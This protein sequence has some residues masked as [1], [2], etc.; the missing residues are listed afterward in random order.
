MVCTSEAAESSQSGRSRPSSSARAIAQRKLWLI[1]DEPVILKSIRRVLEP[2]HDVVT[3]GDAREALT[4][5]ESGERFD[6]IFCDLMMPHLSGDILHARVRERQPALAER[7]VFMTGGA[8]QG[9]IQGF[10][11]EVPNQR[12]EKPFNLQN[13]RGIVGNSVARPAASR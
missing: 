10:L 8:T 1:D 5:L 12:I 2:D 6:V 4:L 13:L 9:R 11:A 7:F 3:L